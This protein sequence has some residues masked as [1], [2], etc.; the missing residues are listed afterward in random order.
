VRPGIAGRGT[1][2]VV[3]AGSLTLRV[4]VTGESVRTLGLATGTPIWLYVKATA[5]RRVGRTPA[6]PT[7]GSRR[8]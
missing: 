6:R 3:R 5:L 1:T 2:V 8:W 4:A 7:P